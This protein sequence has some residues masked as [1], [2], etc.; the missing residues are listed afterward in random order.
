MK[1]R[2]KS[3]MAGAAAL[4]ISAGILVSGA[5]AAFAAGTPGWESDSAA[6]G[7]ITFYNAS[8][9]VITGGSLDDHPLGAFA[10]ASGAGRPGDSK[11][12]LKAY[13]PQVG[14]NPGLW[15]GDTLTGSTDYPNVSAPAA[16]KALTNP[17]VSGVGSDFSMN[18]YI[19]EIPNTS[20]AAGYQDLYEIRLYTSGNGQAQSGS[21]FRA[22]I[23]V[24]TAANTWA[25]VFP[26]AATATSTSLTASPNSPAAS[27]SA[28]TLTAKVLPAGT[29]GAVDFTDGATDL[30]NGTYD[31]A[32][33]TA[34]ITTH[35]GDGA[36]TFSASFA[37]A[38]TGSFTGSSATPLNFTITPSGTP[39]TT[40]LATNPTSPVTADASG[41]ANVTLTATVGPG[42][43]AGS[44]EFFDGSTDLGAATVATGVA[45][46]SVTLTANGSPH[47]LTATFTPTDTTF[48]PSTSLV[49]SFVVVPVNFGSSAIQLQAQDNTAPFA[50]SLSLQVANGTKV[51]LTQ[52]DPTT[53]AGHPVI[54]GD[55]TGHR[56]AW[57]FDGSLSGVSVVDTRPSEAGWTVT[58]QASNFV[59]GSTTITADHVGWTPAAPSG[60]A[61]GVVTAGAAVA[62]VLA[63]ITSHGLGQTT[64]L[65]AAAVGSGLGTA[66]LKSDLDLRIPD[67]SPTGLYN[68][69]LTLTLI[70]P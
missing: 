12:Q 19:G 47:Q 31:A 51:T 60:D 29:A 36:H 15:S 13:T 68:S 50:G 38:D 63:T 32:T 52:V 1:I 23:Q 9:A 64:N 43:L 10:A 54:A 27:G 35:P 34:T 45:T 3:V 4:V 25:V 11:A 53:A 39:T 28:V 18:D 16:V 61:E 42:T 46:K 33:G 14:V 59:N 5:T 8:G 37:P 30:G 20:T 55:A 66:N 24:N 67:T 2:T 57:V 41:N 7:S 70:S 56:H 21:Y 65:G 62:S 26:A 69:T 58:G 48:S 6:L 22:D 17:V 44:V 49:S 40:T